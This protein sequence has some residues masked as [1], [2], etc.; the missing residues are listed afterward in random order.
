[1]SAPHLSSRQLD[2]FLAL[3]EQRSFTRA[4]TLCHLSQPAFS[5]LIKALEDE[6]GARLFDR[7]TR[8][9]D[10]TPEGVNFLESAHRIRAEMRAAVA[11]LRDAV[12]A[13]RAEMAKHKPASGPVDAKLARGGLVDVEFLVHYLQLKGEAADGTPLA[14]TAPQALDPDLATALEGLIA[15]GVIPAGLAAPHAL[16]S[17]ML[18]AGRLLAPD[19]REPPPGAARA[20]AKACGQ[21]TYA[22]LIAALR[23]ETRSELSAIVH[24]AAFQVVKPTAELTPEDYTEAYRTLCNAYDEPALTLHYKAE[25]RQSYAVMLFVPSVRPFDLYD[26]G[27]K[28]GVK[29]YVRRVFIADNTT[30][31]LITGYVSLTQQFAL[32]FFDGRGGPSASVPFPT[33]QRYARGGF[34]IVN[35]AHGDGAVCPLAPRAVDVGHDRRCNGIVAHREVSKTVV[36]DVAE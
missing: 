6:L 24:N 15:A 21:E 19:G 26:P 34:T 10:L 18:V 3:A 30:L 22:A 23:A 7:S 2:A 16:M 11:A 28:N 32:D 35:D 12:L 5:A 25:G 17:R 4:A 14:E 20:L 8:H 1:M 9:V 29:L 36:V 27:F 31:S 13:M 33:I